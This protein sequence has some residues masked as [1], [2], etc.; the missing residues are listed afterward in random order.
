MS[1]LR[2]NKM[3]S[4][5]SVVRDISMRTIELYYIVL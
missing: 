1:L 5:H 2:R 4:V 3:T